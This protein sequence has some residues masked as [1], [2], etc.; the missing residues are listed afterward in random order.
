MLI[1]TRTNLGRFSPTVPRTNQF[2]PWVEGFW[3]AAL[4]NRSRT[5]GA[6]TSPIL[7]RSR[8]SQRTGADR[9]RRASTSRQRT[10]QEVW[11]TREADEDNPPSRTARGS[12]QTPTAS[13]RGQVCHS[14]SALGSRMKRSPCFFERTGSGPSELVGLRTGLSVTHHGSTSGGSAARPS[15]SV[16]P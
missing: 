5:R 15:P 6:T 12:S 16:S 4:L 11:R 3:P 13:C 9:R 1:F 8:R 7:S 14:P 2:S 10:R